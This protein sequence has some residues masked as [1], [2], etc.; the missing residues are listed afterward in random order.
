MKASRVLGAIPN[1]A[2]ENRREG[3]S[4]VALL[5]PG[6]HL[7]RA[8]SDAYGPQRSS[9]GVFTQSNTTP[10]TRFS[11]LG[12]KQACRGWPPRM[13]LDPP[14]FG[15]SGLRIEVTG[16]LRHPFRP[17]PT[18][19][20][21]ASDTERSFGHHLPSTDFKTED[22]KQDGFH[23]QV[24]SE[25]IPRDSFHGDSSPSPPITSPHLPFLV[26]ASADAYN[27]SPNF[28]RLF[29]GSPKHV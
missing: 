6:S 3:S 28:Y 16:L 25:W 17:L 7:R 5:R 19:G 1:E 27:P 10:S 23:V 8:D 21:F 13:S 14:R 18:R 20:F 26:L 12:P 22:H 24:G 2:K 15:L 29:Y 11:S 4:S 9:L